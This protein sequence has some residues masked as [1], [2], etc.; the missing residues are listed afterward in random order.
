MTR[1]I[2]FTKAKLCRALEAAREKGFR[3]LVR[4]DGTLVFEKDTNPQDAEKPLEQDQEMV[5]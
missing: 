4:T 1:P 5:L 3:V 2:P